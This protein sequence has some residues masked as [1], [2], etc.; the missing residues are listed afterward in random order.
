MSINTPKELIDEELDSL[1]DYIEEKRREM[2]EWVDQKEAE[3]DIYQPSSQ[4]HRF[5]AA[6]IF[7]RWPTAENNLLSESFEYLP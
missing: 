2:D 5:W 7:A 1:Y 4:I 6:R 3:K